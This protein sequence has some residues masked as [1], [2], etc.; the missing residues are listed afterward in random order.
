MCQSSHITQMASST[1]STT[2]VLA[3]CCSQSN[4]FGIQ[5]GTLAT[6]CERRGGCLCSQQVTENGLSTTLF[7]AF[8]VNCISDSQEG[9]SGRCSSSCNWRC[10]RTWGILDS[11]DNCCADSFALLDTPDR[12]VHKLR[13][14]CLQA[15]AE[16]LGRLLETFFEACEST[17]YVDVVTIML[18]LC[19][20]L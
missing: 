14:C 5:V 15:G 17:H 18:L 3:L 10:N 12:A 9:S 8:W 7:I 6:R 16:P 20:H 19:Y 1:G 11:P 4:K 2:A 13:G